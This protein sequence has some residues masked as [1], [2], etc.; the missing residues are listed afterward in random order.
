MFPFLQLP[1]GRVKSS[2]DPARG[3]YVAHS[4]FNSSDG[5]VVRASASAAVDSGLI[6][7]LVK[8]IILNGIHSFPA[9]RSAL[10]GQCGE[11]AGKFTCC[12]LGKGTER[13]SSVLVW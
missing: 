5:R 12:A 4:C 9:G 11:Q 8:P 3:P 6:P 7:S 13:D 10:K 2:S 1:A